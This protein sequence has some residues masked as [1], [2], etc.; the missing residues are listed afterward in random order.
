MLAK[1]PLDTTTKTITIYNITY[2]VTA[3]PTADCGRG[4]YLLTGPRGASYKTNRN[5]PE[6]T[7]MFLVNAKARCY[8]LPLKNV[9][10]SDKDGTL[11]VTQS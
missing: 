10:L 11:K 7:S 5:V 1:M 3:D 6:P 2:T 9:W 4:G 8:T